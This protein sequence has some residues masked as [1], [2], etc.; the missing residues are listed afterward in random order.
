[1]YPVNIRAASQAPTVVNEAATLRITWCTSVYARLKPRDLAVRAYGWRISSS[2]APRSSCASLPA[3]ANPIET[4]G[5]MIDVQPEAPELGNHPSWT[6]K[7]MI[8]R[9][10]I[11]NGGAEMAAKPRPTTTLSAARFCFHAASRPIGIASARLTNIPAAT[12]L[13]V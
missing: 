4:A 1:M 2:S 13:S 11:Q 9:Y 10:A 12:S 5:R 7:T 8:N 3:L 6:A